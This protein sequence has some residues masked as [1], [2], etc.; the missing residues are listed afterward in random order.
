MYMIKN[1]VVL[2]ATGML[3]TLLVGCSLGIR[4]SDTAISIEQPV[5]SAPVSINIPSTPIEPDPFVPESGCS[6]CQTLPPFSPGAT[7][8]PLTVHV[9]EYGAVGSGQNEHEQ[10][11]LAVNAAGEGGRVVF[12]S[13][14]VYII[15]KMLDAQ[16][17]QFWQPSSSQVATLK[18]CNT[19]SLL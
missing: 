12:E 15:C 11:Q 7:S 13:G 1:V 4:S 18:R 14:R 10:N 8:K 17:G 2:A 5:G 19:Q 6:S 16:P 9:S 3:G